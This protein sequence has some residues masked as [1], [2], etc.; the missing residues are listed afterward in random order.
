MCKPETDL[1]RAGIFRSS[2]LVDAVNYVGLPLLTIY[3]FSMFA[4][5]WIDGRGSWAHV[6]I[7]WERWQSLNAAAL[8]F[9]ASLVAFNIARFNENLQRERDFVAAR[10]FLPS[11]LSSL[12]EYCC[13]SAS[14]YKNLWELNARTR[15]ALIPPDLPQGYREVFSN[16][17]RHAD[18]AVGTYLSNIIVHLQVHDS[19]LREFVVQSSNGQNRG[20]DKYALISYLYRLGELY[21]LISQLFGFARGEE[22]FNTS[23]L[24]WEDLRNAYGILDVAADNIFIDRQMNLE[25]F[26]KRALQRTEEQASARAK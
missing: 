8:A 14:I 17:I 3:V 2:V 10:A 20:V 25:A 6:Q 7:V 4:Y 18:P 11:T 26:T 15:V 23:G 12:V 9:I 19:R 5:P 22:T 24:N 16:C 21:A 13:H 1:H